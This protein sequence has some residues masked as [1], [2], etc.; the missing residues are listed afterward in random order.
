MIFN[1]SNIAYIVWFLIV[2]ACAWNAYDIV[3]RDIANTELRGYCRHEAITDYDVE[4]CERL[5][6]NIYLGASS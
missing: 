1:K 4:I 3:V 6:P 2:G 5:Y